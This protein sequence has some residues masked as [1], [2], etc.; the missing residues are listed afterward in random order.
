MK[1]AI[2][3][4][5]PNLS[6]TLFNTETEEILKIKST[7]NQINKN[8]DNTRLKHRCF[9]IT[10]DK[11]NIFVA[12]RRNLLI[13]N[14]KLK[15]IN[16]VEDI[17][18]QNTHQITY[19]KNKLIITMCRKDCVGFYD[20]KNNKMEYFHP[21][22][23]WNSHYPDKNDKDPVIYHINSVVCK[24]DLLYVMLH[25][26]R[27]KSQ[28][29]T[30]NLLTKKIINIKTLNANLAHNI[31][32]NN[33]IKT[34]HTKNTQLNVD[35]TNFNIYYGPNNAKLEKHWFLRG[36]TGD[37][38]KLVF[39]AFSKELD[40]NRRSIHGSFI[41]ILNTVDNKITKSSFIEDIGA[42]ND[43]RRIDGEDFCHH[44]EYKFPFKNF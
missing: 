18:D 35:N 8:A 37:K 9:G 12:N 38:D 10:W 14:N 32:V 42:I 23:G 43:I 15:C 1:I 5:N 41:K 4:D 28:I 2:T 39:A 11:K 25:N 6:L 29:L 17:L 16:V 40:M 7:P 31:Y 33:S 36:L 27:E 19:Y 3:S 22:K 24:D 20:L 44:N 34:L 13:Y 30:L 26:L 21:I